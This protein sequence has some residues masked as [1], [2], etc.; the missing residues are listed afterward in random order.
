MSPVLLC[1]QTD[2]HDKTNIRF[3]QF[4]RKHLQGVQSLSLCHTACLRPKNCFNC[5]WMF[6]FL[7]AS[8]YYFILTIS[9]AVITI[10]SWN[11]VTLSLSRRH[12]R[13]VGWI[14]RR[15]YPQNSPYF[16]SFQMSLWWAYNKHNSW[17][18]DNIMSYKCG[19]FS[20]PH[21]LRDVHNI[22]LVYLLLRQSL[23]IICVLSN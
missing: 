3:P 13:A 7:T 6:A 1:G 9:S 14:I 23:T 16:L 15:F 4:L 19:Y 20:L 21:M 18:P 22:M 8:R 5:K 10:S 2:R 12:D 17:S 11:C